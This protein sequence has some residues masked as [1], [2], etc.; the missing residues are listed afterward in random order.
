MTI[1]ECFEKAPIEN[2]VSSLAS[3]PE[4]LI[5]VGV[6]SEMKKSAAAYQ[7]LLKSKGYNT[8]IQLRNINKHSLSDIVKVIT[9]IIENEDDCVFD[10]T[11]GEDLVI[12]AVGI[13]FEKFK[14]IK[15]FKLQR[16]N[17]RTGKLI[18]CDED[19]EI[20]FEGSFA[21]SVN[22][23]ISLYGGVVVPQ[24]PQPL[25]T[26]SIEDIDILWEMVC[27]DPGRWNNTINL[28][29]EFEN[30]SSIQENEKT[31]L[32]DFNFL[33]KPIENITKKFDKFISLLKDFSNKGIITDFSFSHNIMK[34][35]YK[36]LLIR[37][38]LK[39]AG[40][41][42]EMKTFFEAR[43]II[44]DDQPYF[45]DCLLSTT[46]DWD[47]VLHNPCDMEKD[48]TNEIDVVLMKGLIPVFISCKNGRIDGEEL[49]KLNTVANRFGGKYAKKMLIA[50]D[51][52][53]HSKDSVEAYIQRTKDM[54]INFIPNAA[55]LTKKQWQQKLK[56]VVL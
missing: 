3:N 52:E 2:M 13:V 54:H 15:P 6:E 26:D 35:T 49:Y 7:N 8:E 19:N 30:R 17:L 25:A 21:L 9:H 56:N 41:V 14:N 18:D 45:T 5:F 34:Y 40:N 23:V 55:K 1:V 22:E 42:L 4:K 16:F 12:L 37:H 47:G 31:V 10:I 32:I 36:N 27:E 38:A 29:Q 33:P 24:E 43:N 11:G 28:L 51:F 53:R 20:S 44:E 50:T 46:I 39:K 48:T